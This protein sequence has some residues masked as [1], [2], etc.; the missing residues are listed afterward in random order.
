MGGRREIASKIKRN[1]H[2][3]ERQGVRGHDKQNKRG[4]RPHASDFRAINWSLILIKQFQKKNSR[5]RLDLILDLQAR[6]VGVR[7]A[8]EPLDVLALLVRDA[9]GG[10]CGIRD[11]VLERKGHIGDA[12]PI[13]SVETKQLHLEEVE[14]VGCDL[15]EDL[16]AQGVT[17]GR[18]DLAGDLVPFIIDLG[19]LV[20]AAPNESRIGAEH[21][22]D[23]VIL[24]DKDVRA[25]IDLDDPLL[26]D[27][28]GVI[29]G[30]ILAPLLPLLGA[31]VAF[32]EGV[33]RANDRMGQDCVGVALAHVNLLVIGDALDLGAH[34]HRKGGAML[35]EMHLVD[36]G[37]AQL[38][39]GDLGVD[40]GAQAK[41]LGLRAI[42]DLPNRRLA[43][44]HAQ[45]GE[46]ARD[47][48]QDG[49]SDDIPLRQLVAVGGILIKRSD[50]KH[51]IS[52]PPHSLNTLKRAECNG[53]ICKRQDARGQTWETPGC[54]WV[55][56]EQ[57]QDARE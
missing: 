53:W 19:L 31:H 46:A 44:L 36:Q 28:S 57:R 27:V 8:E 39:G 26:V 50:R 49:S 20:N 12:I 16:G 45:V 37:G 41:N 55:D 18:E 22:D 2:I 6:H 54:T 29:L 25:I 15:V 5:L 3:D 47:G 1:R 4:K 11:E 14:I 42:H 40:A 23:G 33:R 13:I 17:A 35:K 21:S 32:V 10:P 7:D 24:V 48:H 34:G 9:L 43:A 51:S 52:P 38:V 30:I 56:L